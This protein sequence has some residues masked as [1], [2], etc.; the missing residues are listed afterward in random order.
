MWWRIT[1]LALAYLV[2]GAHFL[3]YG[4]AIA[5]VLITA[6]PLLLFSK[7][8]ITVTLLQLG[9]VAGTLLVWLPTAYRL[10]NV[11]LSFDQPWIRMAIILGCVMLCNLLIAWAAGAMKRRF[12]G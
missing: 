12:Q 8:A 3:R 4:N 7:R 1:L 9:L 5:A 11:R 6:A 2:M 10:I